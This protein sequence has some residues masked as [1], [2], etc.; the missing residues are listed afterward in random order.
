MTKTQIINKTIFKVLEPY[1][2]HRP[3]I[4]PEAILAEKHI[5]ADGVVFCAQMYL[6]YNTDQWGRVE[7]N[8]CPFML[9]GIFHFDGEDWLEDLLHTYTISEEDLRQ[10]RHTK[11]T[12][13]WAVAAGE[14]MRMVVS[15]WRKLRGDKC[16][17]S[18][19]LGLVEGN[20]PHVGDRRVDRL[21]PDE[22]VSIETVPPDYA[23][24]EPVFCKV[25]EFVFAKKS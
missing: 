3:R 25:P 14:R 7:N 8:P 18:S 9:H 6:I 24:K 22:S 11:I 19:T 13:S 2:W 17:S 5:K 15:G 12:Q 16:L 20:R 4:H 10:E 1:G 21:A 23:P